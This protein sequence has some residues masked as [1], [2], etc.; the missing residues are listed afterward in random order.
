MTKLA[1][2]WVDNRLFAPREIENN[3]NAK[4]W[5]EKKYYGIFEQGISPCELPQVSPQ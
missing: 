4:F 1:R 5:S 3:A 2:E